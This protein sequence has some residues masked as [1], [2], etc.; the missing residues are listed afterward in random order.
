MWLSKRIPA[1]F[2]RPI[3]NGYDCTATVVVAVLGENPVLFR[4]AIESWIANRPDRIIVVID[5]ADTSGVCDAIAREYAQVETFF[6][7]VPGKRAALAAGVDA[8][9]TDIVV[10]ADSDVVWEPGVLKK[11]KMPFANPKI[12]GVGTR[13]FMMPSNGV[14][15]TRWERLADAYLDLRYSAE[16]PATTLLS[17]A[18]G[19]LS[20]RTS[21]YRTELLQSL[22]EPFLNETFLG[23]PCISGDDKC[24]TYLVL[25]SGYHTWCQLNAHIRS[26]FRPD[27]TGF[28]QQRVRWTRNSFRSELRALGQGWLWRYPYLALVTLDKNI[29]LLTQLNGPVI[30]TLAAI[31]GNLWLMVALI[32]WWHVTR[33]VKISAHLFRQPRDWLILPLFIG[34]SFFLSVVKFYAFFTMNKQGWITRSMTTVESRGPVIGTPNLIPTSL[35]DVRPEN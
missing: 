2:Y 21:A 6:G 8:S 20:G 10:L 25:K 1:M 27:F 29:G 9:N 23:K 14:N 17:C 35:P 16:V 33:A 7:P 19:C 22:R 18:V 4:K 30:F 5:L 12:G 3:T 13:A 31:H 28:V 32:A 34:T 26:T 11:M 24:Y 15:P